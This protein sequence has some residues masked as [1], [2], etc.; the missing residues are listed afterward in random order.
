MEENLQI[1][2][3][4]YRASLLGNI[5]AH[6]QSLQ[7]YD[8]MALELLQNADDAKAKK[9]VFDIQDD[10]LK[11]WNSG[12]FSS[13]GDLNNECTFDGANCDFHRLIE[14]GSGGKQVSSENIGRFGIGFVSTYQVTDYPVVVSN[15][16]K[17]KLEP[18]TGEAEVSIVDNT[19]GT[20]FFLPWANSESDIRRAL[21]SSP[22]TDEHIEQVFEDCQKVLRHSL[23]FLKN[24]QQAEVR[25]NGQL[26]LLVE[27][28]RDRR[29]LFV[30]FKPENKSEHWLILDST[31]N[32]NKKKIAFDK[33]SQLERAGRKDKISIAIGG[34]GNL[35]SDNGLLYAFLPTQKS[36][37]LPLHI[38][39]DFFPESSL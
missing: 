30:S 7:G 1:F 13:C 29:G 15:N 36:T 28:N 31:I 4:D 25:R 39:G 12:V 32:K 10:G 17:I 24:L 27:L 38:N 20:K 18:E 21:H 14:F 5:G 33:Y 11:V 22:V 2:R 37:G 19:R 9:I 23:L 34:E 8:T 6:L 26:E 3:V 16:L 35:D